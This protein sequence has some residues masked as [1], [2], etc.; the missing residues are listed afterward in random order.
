MNK[1]IFFFDIDGTILTFRKPITR[2]LKK[3]IKQLQKHGHLCF[4]ASGRP[5]AFLS[6]DILEVGFD[7]YILCNGAIIIYQG[8]VIKNESL[9]EKELRELIDLLE[10]TNTEYI[11]ETSTKSYIKKEY[12]KMLLVYKMGRVDFKELIHDYDFDEQIKRTCKIET[13]PKNNEI[14]NMIIQNLKYFSYVNFDKGFIEIYSQDISKATA[15]KEMINHFHISFENTYCFGDGKNDIEMFHV[16]NNSY[17][18]D[19]ASDEVKKEA[20]YICPSVYKNG[21][22]VT[23]KKIIRKKLILFILG[24]FFYINRVI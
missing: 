8:Q 14:R 18:M 9:D 7:G 10:S 5:P 15:I 24:S 2:K 17:A 19:N 16:V 6:K 13:F 4:I 21:V 1:K 20:K 12:K 22:A 23:L 3:A 11:L